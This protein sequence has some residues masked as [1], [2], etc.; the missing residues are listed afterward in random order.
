ML[1]R[2]PYTEFRSPKRETELPVSTRKRFY[3]LNE[4]QNH[5]N[6]IVNQKDSGYLQE[7][8]DKYGKKSINRASGLQNFLENNHSRSSSIFTN[9]S[10]KSGA[11]QFSFKPSNSPSVGRKISSN[12]HGQMNCKYYSPHVPKEW[13]YTYRSPKLYQS[14]SKG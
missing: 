13:N 11:V 4:D 1:E 5:Q 10:K 14:P 12:P 7:L 6:P 3:A 2:S 8:R 9:E